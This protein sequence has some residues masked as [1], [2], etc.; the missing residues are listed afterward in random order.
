MN[1]QAQAQQQQQQQQAYY[2]RNKYKMAA[3][4]MSPTAYDE[5]PTLYIDSSNEKRCCNP[6]A[7]LLSCLFC[8]KVRG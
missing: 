3:Y 5:N 1:S 7:M 4:K 8:Q 2:G 6:F